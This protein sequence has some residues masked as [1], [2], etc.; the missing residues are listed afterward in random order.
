MRNEFMDLDFYKQG[1]VS[2]IIPTYNRSGLLIEAIQSV[3]NQT[4]RPIECIVV[5]DGST[6]NTKKLVSQL[7]GNNNES[8]TLRYIYQ[9]KAGSQVGRNTGTE[10]ATGEY[11]QYLD[12][13]DLLYPDKIR[14]QVYFL[15]ENKECDGVWGGWAKG[16]PDKH[17]IIISLARE[18]LLTQ[19][20]TE[21][22]IVNFS[23][24]FRRNLIAKIGTWDVSIKRN[25]EIDFQVRGLLAGGN[26]QYQS[27]IGGLWRIHEEERIANTT[28]SKE[29]LNFYQKWE[30][31]LDKKGLFNNQMKE[32]IS[33][34]YFW[35]AKS[36]G[37]NKNKRLTLLK[38]AV[39]LNPDINF[40]K[41]SKMRLLQKMF[42]LT[43]SLRIW[44]RITI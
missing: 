10:A 14:N 41:S 30:N 20:L 19:L 31:I 15:Q 17:E 5:D 6:D 32:N 11:I 16:S 44:N 39:R 43:N 37:E 7:I 42:G 13:D 40:I 38:E 18:D 23:F 26:Y 28:G 4:Y 22:C 2:V 29:F 25:Q 3:I 8:F 1:L 35:L 24:L 36:S 21:H 12:S 27:Q 33:H 34:F 9:K